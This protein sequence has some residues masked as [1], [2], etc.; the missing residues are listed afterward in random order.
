MEGRDQREIQ[1]WASEIAGAVKAHL[2]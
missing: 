1:A 2:G